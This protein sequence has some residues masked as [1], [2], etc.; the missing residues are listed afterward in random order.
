[1]VAMNCLKGLATIEVKHSNRDGGGKTGEVTP[2]EKQRFQAKKCT[3]GERPKAVP[4]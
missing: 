1:M 3:S 4:Y 2:K